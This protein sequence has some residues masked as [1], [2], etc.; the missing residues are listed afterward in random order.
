MEKQSAIIHST[1]E[2]DSI[3]RF[4]SRFG[5]NFTAPAKGESLSNVGACNFEG[6]GY[7][8]QFGKVKIPETSVSSGC[9]FCAQ[10]DSYG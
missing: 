7:F 2:W 10:K 4:F 3:Q 1:L 8:D 9:S 5:L 6:V